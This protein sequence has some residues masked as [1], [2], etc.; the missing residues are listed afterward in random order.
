VLAAATAAGIVFL[1]RRTPASPLRAWWLVA[2]TGWGVSAMLGMVTHGFDLDAQVSTLLW[3]PLYI[4]LGVAQ[5]IVV[6]ASVDAW[7]GTN[8][9]QR[10]L[11]FMLAM[12]VV[13]YW[14]TWHWAGDF[15]VFVVFSAGTT[16]VALLIHARLALHGLDGAAWVAGGLAANLASGALQATDFTARLVWDFDHN[17]LFHL[18]QMIALALLLAGLG[19]ML[20]AHPALTQSTR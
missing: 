10:L 9:A 19:R 5:A 2:L 16:I 14:A 7:R 4:G 8:A 17:G 6:V 20:A 11:P 13:F 18:A 3:Q 1:V 12:T 15:L